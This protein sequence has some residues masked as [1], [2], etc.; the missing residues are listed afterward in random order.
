M[1]RG[2]PSAATFS[3][4]GAPRCAANARLTLS[5]SSISGRASISDSTRSAEACAICISA[6][7]LASSVTGLKNSRTSIMK[8][9]SVPVPM[10]PAMMNEPPTA[11]ATCTAT[12]ARMRISGKY[13]AASTMLRTEARY[14]ALV[15]SPKSRL[16]AS[17]RT[18]ALEVSTPMM[19]SL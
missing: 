17:S 14:I 1:R 13:T 12:A 5:E 6:N 3:R 9:I 11:K 8:A 15:N 18:N 16:L 2:P 7:Q 4:P 19:D 10:T